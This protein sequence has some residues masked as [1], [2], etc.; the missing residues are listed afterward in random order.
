MPNDLNYGQARCFPKHIWMLTWKR[1]TNY[2]VSFCSVWIWDSSP[3]IVYLLHHQGSIIPGKATPLPILQLPIQEGTLE[4]M[5]PQAPNLPWNCRGLR[6]FGSRSCTYL[7]LLHFL[8]ELRFRAGS[9]CLCS[10]CLP[11]IML[12]LI[13][14]PEYFDHSLC[15]TLCSLLYHCFLI[16]PL[17][18]A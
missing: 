18:Q 5:Y 8:H 2:S 16:Q 15:L 17:Q 10:S 6:V 14:I 1:R 13:N 9:I 7:C 3:A 4:N 11:L 12:I